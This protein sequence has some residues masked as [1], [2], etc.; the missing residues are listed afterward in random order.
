[1]NKTV[2]F[3][4]ERTKT[5]TYIMPTKDKS[6]ALLPSDPKARKALP[7][8]SGV[9]KYFP[10]A[11]AYIAH[12]SKVGNDQHNPGQ[13]LHWNRGV[14]E[15]HADTLARHLLEHGTNDSDGVRHTGKVAWRAL[16][17]LES[18]LEKEENA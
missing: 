7:I 14:S 15:D 6:A 12:V 5:V 17:L 9:L 18:E 4:D 2:A 3:V 13:P 10:R 8:Y 1:M 16:A 11:I